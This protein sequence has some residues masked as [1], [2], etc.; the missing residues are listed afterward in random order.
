MPHPLDEALAW[1]CGPALAGMK[2][3]NLVALNCVQI[4]DLH[5]R[6]HAYRQ[7]LGGQGI[8]LEPLCDCG[9]RMLLLVCRP[10]RLSAA[11]ER[12]AARRILDGAGYPAGCDM[13]AMLAHLKTRLSDLEDFPH[14]IGLFLDYPPADV[15][16]FQR[17]GGQGC[18]LCG[19]WKVYS[20]V[21]R[22]RRLFRRYDRCRADAVR[23][24]AQG[25]S[26]LKIFP[27]AS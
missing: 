6:L 11:L 20:N 24:V 4:P 18:K 3:G 12:P 2:A 23:R 9:Q 16:G 13:G 25:E 22:A 15:L 26:I 10:D 7:T 14:E 19:H 5:Q 21:R 8:L 1:H 17:R 27:A